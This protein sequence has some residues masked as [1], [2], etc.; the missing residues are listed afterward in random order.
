MAS[1]LVV[2]I[3]ELTRRSG[4]FRDLDVD[5][6]T[7]EFVFNDPRID[8]S[9][10][11]HAGLHVESTSGGIVVDGAVSAQARGQ[12]S[13]CLAD[14]GLAITSEVDEIYQRVPESDDVYPLEGD[15][16]DLRPMVREAVLLAIPEAPLCSPTCAGICPVCGADLNR[17]T[18]GCARATNDERWSMLDQLKGTLPE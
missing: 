8:D 17:A 6:P 7:S 1:P 10:D 14:L 11:V 16:L 3:L 5:V 12:C 9:R 4:A 13:R 2:N 15:Q 18:C